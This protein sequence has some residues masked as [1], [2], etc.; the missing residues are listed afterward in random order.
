MHSRK[1]PS[2]ELYS[3]PFV[4]KQFILKALLKVNTFSILTTI[5]T[6]FK[7]FYHW[8]ATVIIL[9]VNKDKHF[10]QYFVSE[11]MVIGSPKLELDAILSCH[12]SADNETQVICK[13][14]KNSLPLS[15]CSSTKYFFETRFHYVSQPDLE[16][17]T[18]L[19]QLLSSWIIGIYHHKKLNRKSQCSRFWDRVQVDLKFTM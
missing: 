6:R 11:C 17:V 12:L 15:H 16:F 13:S 18:L 2:S 1:T 4:K 14:S 9:Q 8:H 10:W 3:Q 7:Y 5:M 19:P